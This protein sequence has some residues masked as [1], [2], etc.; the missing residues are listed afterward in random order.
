MK[1]SKFDTIKKVVIWLML[2]ATIGSAVISVI[3]AAMNM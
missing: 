1:K 2:I 3:I